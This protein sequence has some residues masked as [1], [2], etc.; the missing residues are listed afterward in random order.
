MPDGQWSMSR[1]FHALLLGGVV[2]SLRTI[3]PPVAWQLRIRRLQQKQAT[4]NELLLFM[5]IVGEDSVT[6]VT[7]NHKNSQD[8]EIIGRSIQEIY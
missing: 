1:F 5:S 6:P 7:I 3:V 2:V 8:R 4:E